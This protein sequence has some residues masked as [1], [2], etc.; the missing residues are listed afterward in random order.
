MLITGRGCNLDSDPALIEFLLNP[1]NYPEHPV[2]I[3]HH[4]THI[5]HVFVAD[6]LV[7]KIK[8]P[9]DFGFLDFTTLAARRFYCKEEVRLNSRLAKG[10]Y[11]GV[12]PLYRSGNTYT[13]RNLPGSTT[14]EYAVKMKKVPEERLLSSLIGEGKLLFGQL[15]DVGMLLGGFHRRA[16][17]HTA[18]F[19][20]AIESVRM[21]TEENFEQVRP[22]LGITVDEALYDH[23]VSYSHNFLKTEEPLFRTRKKEGFVREVHGDLHSSHVCL[24]DPPVIMDC[25]EFNKRF[26]ITD[27]A[28]DIAFLLM[29]LNY[30]GRFDLSGQLFQSY[31]RTMPECAPPGLLVFYKAYRAVVRAKIEGFTADSVKDETE[32]AS[33]LRRARDYF[34]LARHYLE[35]DGTRFNPVV[36]VGVSGSGKSAIARGLFPDGLTLRSDEVRKE[37]GNV[38]S[39][40]HAYVEWGKDLY[41][42]ETTRRT[43]RVMGERAV[44]AAQGGRRVIVDATFLTASTRLELYRQC[45]REHLNPFFVYCVADAQV[46]R[47]RV[48]RRIAEGGDP[49]DAHL[50]ILDEQLRMV[51]EPDELPCFRVLKLKTEDPPETIQQ[52]LRE[53]L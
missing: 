47:E 52:A 10:I 26:R 42:A 12:I 25:I 6:H 27:V 37:L 35:K 28:D 3:V 53:F 31:E 15:R 20:G 9:V 40:R 50:A 51:E 44:T 19:Y 33:A 32:R 8:K 13:F 30:S 46:L 45:L 24:I 49:S 21:N 1:A 29:D 38:G 23:L 39:D 7:Y 36:F 18:G 14:A 16:P 34:A 4:E 41:A 2:A 22:Y 11:L 48:R 43:Y 5:S 17:R